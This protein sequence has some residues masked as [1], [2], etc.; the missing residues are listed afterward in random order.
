MLH[1]YNPA[2]DD[3]FCT[4]KLTDSNARLYSSTGLL[5]VEKIL[6]IYSEEPVRHLR[7][8]L[9]DLSRSLS[10]VRY[11]RRILYIALLRGQLQYIISYLDRNIQYDTIFI[12][13]TSL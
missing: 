8:L 9:L 2:V 4:V 11:Y 10:E 6:S 5:L 3:G 1:F 7:S 12:R 13:D